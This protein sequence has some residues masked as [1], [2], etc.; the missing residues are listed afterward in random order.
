MRQALI[1]S[2]T[3]SK[4]RSIRVPLRR[5]THEPAVEG[6]EERLCPS[7]YLLVSSFDSNSVLRYDESAGAFVD[8]FVPWRQQS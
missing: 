6:L 3:T 2:H 8:A 4:R 5:L 7:G 1:A